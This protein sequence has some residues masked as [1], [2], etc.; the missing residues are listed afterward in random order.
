MSRDLDTQ[1]AEAMGW[2]RQP[3][4]ASVLPDPTLPKPTF[5][6]LVDL[7]GA[8][9]WVTPDGTSYYFRAGYPFGR[10]QELPLHFDFRAWMADFVNAESL[11]RLI[12]ATPEQ[13]AQAFL[14]AIKQ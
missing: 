5:T 3:I 13:R 6:I 12:R 8:D 9:Y 14:E 1:C 2:V 11:W 7:G 10:E 4:P